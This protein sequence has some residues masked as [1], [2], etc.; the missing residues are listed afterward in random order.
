MFFWGM[1][2]YKSNNL[3]TIKLYDNIKKESTKLYKKLSNL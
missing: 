1:T 3:K 2:E